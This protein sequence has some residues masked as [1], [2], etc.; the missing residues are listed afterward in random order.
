M[1]EKR[2]QKLLAIVDKHVGEAEETGSSLDEA[3]QNAAD[4]FDKEVEQEEKEKRRRA[5][6]RRKTMKNETPVERVI[7]RSHEADEKFTSNFY[8]KWLPKSVVYSPLVE[9]IAEAIHICRLTGRTLEEYRE[10]ERNIREVMKRGG[11]LTEE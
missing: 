3:A 7:R 9:D 2:K 11:L 1:N 4:E 5:N 8:D 6:Q 10:G